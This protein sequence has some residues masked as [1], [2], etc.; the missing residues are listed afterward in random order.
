MNGQGE[1]DGYFGSTY[2]YIRTHP[3]DDGAEPLPTNL[4]CWLSPDIG[5][6]ASANAFSDQAVQGIANQV[7]VR[8]TNGGG[9]AAVSAYVDF[10]VSDP[11]TAF[12]PTVS[13][14]VS[15]QFVNV[16]PYSVTIASFSWTPLPTQVGH[17]CLLAR[18]A[19]Y[20]GDAYRSTITF[21]PREDRHVAQR[22][23]S[24]VT[25]GGTNKIDFAFR[26]VNPLE[27]M[28]KHTITVQELRSKR[29]LATMRAAIG[30]PVQI[31]TTPLQKFG[32]VAEG[33]RGRASKQLTV[34]LEGGEDRAATLEASRNPE[35]RPGD[36]HILKVTHADERNHVVGGLVVLVQH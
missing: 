17:R 8:V 23:I 34:T 29:Q 22:N 15:G 5:I 21:E 28:G 13:S 14:P 1:G 19:L 36:A 18:V 12:N 2:L 4:D 3:Q 11:A 7:N 31:G 30:Y 32:V 24:I 35:T 9:I 33:G 16:N 25:L 6:Q 20:P 10:F 27:R 26:I